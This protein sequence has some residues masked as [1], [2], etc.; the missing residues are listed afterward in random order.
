[1]LL[2]VAFFALI[3]IYTTTALWIGKPIT[4]AQRTPAQRCAAEWGA[5]VS[6]AVLDDCE[7]REAREEQD[8]AFKQAM[9]EAHR[10]ERQVKY[11]VEGDKHQRA[12]L[13]YRNESGGTEQRTVYLP[14]S[15]E[16]WRAPGTFVYLSAQNHGGSGVQTTIFVEGRIL[17]EAEST[18][19]YGIATASGRIPR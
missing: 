14:W 3:A 18:A 11:V 4:A 5:D 1:M 17:Q 13:T 19:E 2:V 10:G 9:I 12:D 7:K 15:L 8:R 16:M 6:K